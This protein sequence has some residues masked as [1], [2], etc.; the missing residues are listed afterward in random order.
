M[1]FG[2]IAQ[3]LVAVGCWLIFGTMW[4]WTFANRGPAFDQLRSLLVVAAIALTV[5]GVTLAWVAWNVRVYRRGDRREHPVAASHDYGVDVTGRPVDAD[6]GQMRS[7]RY[8]EIDLVPGPDGRLMKSYSAP[9]MEEP[10]EEEAAS[11][12]A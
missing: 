9:G 7:Q 2:R 5:I 1:K 4:W 6:F 8:V 10:T 11:C 12:V 3:A